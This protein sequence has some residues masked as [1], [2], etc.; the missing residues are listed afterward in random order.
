M[1]QEANVH[2]LCT[3]RRMSSQRT[4][5]HYF[6]FHLLSCNSRVASQWI[7][8]GRSQWVGEWVSEWVDSCRIMP[9][10]HF[11]WGYK[12]GFWIDSA[13]RR[14]DTIS[15]DGWRAWRW[16]KVIFR[17][18][19]LLPDVLGSSPFSSVFDL[20]SFFSVIVFCSLEVNKKPLG[21]WMANQPQ[22]QPFGL[23]FWLQSK[24]KQMHIEVCGLS[25]WFY[26]WCQT[27]FS[28]ERNQDNLNHRR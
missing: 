24:S 1:V 10:F 19:S 14:M 25:S 21:G 13:R 8:A 22:W 23:V 20:V 12:N 11:L 7:W 5:W 9:Y 18:I 17:V 15:F 28:G 3:V 6:Y 16:Q 4:W 2:T 27:D 26:G